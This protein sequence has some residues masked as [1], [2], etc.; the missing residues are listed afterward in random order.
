[1]NAT[2]L[3]KAGKL[4][5][6]VDAQVKE[7]KANPGDPNRRL[8]LF[9]LLAFTGDL[10]RAR[11]QIEAVKYDNPEKDLVVLRYARLLDSEAL[12]RKAFQDAGPVLPSY[13]AEPPFHMRMRIDA[14][15][16]FLPSHR[17]TEAAAILDGARQAMPTLQVRLNGKDYEG[18]H[19][20]DDLLGT[21]LEVMN[22]GLYYWLPLE[23]VVSISMNDPKVPRDLLWI[24]ARIELVD[25]RSGEVFLPA[26]YPGSHLHPDDQV[27]L[28][29]L[30]DWKTWEGG[31]VLG[32]GQRTYL[33]G[34]DPVGVLEWRE[35]RVLG[36]R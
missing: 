14:M 16:N 17:V 4:A 24:P 26:L 2:E 30:T 11:R 19:D 8:F 36:G 7:V 3:F 21:I 10:D 5:D 31:P 34:D 1:M 32:I 22:D 9:E 13:F 33:A 15:T 20:A 6:A 25:G 29:R 27:K 23:Q 35:L 12:R 28:G 18:L